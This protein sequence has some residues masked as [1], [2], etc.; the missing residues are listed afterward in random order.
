MLVIGQFRTTILNSEKKTSKLAPSSIQDYDVVKQELAARQAATDGLQPGDPALAVERILDIA[1][2][3]NLSERQA[4]HLPLRIPLGSDAIDVIRRK[5]HE[6]L[7]LLDDWDE[8]ASST[9]F[10]T[11][12]TVP[13]Y[14]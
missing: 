7:K 1:R 2:G 9:D 4:R 12:G 5:C 10:P 8:F 13:R 3:E 6:T 14:Y 11:T